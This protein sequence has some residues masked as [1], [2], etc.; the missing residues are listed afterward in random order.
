MSTHYGISCSR[1]PAVIG[2]FLKF[3]MFE[4]LLPCGIIFKNFTILA[5]LP[6]NLNASL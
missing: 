5:Y 2:L 3:Y 4:L 6:G 1:F